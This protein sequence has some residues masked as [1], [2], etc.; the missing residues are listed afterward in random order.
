VQQIVIIGAGGFAREVLDV[1]EAANEDRSRYEVLGYVVDPKYGAPG[2]LVNDKPILGGF[3]WLRAHSKDVFAVC[4]VGSSHHRYGLVAR[5]REAGSRFISV[6]HPTVVST[7]WV[8]IAEGVVIAAGSVLTNRISIGDHVH[9]N[10][11]CTIGHDVIMEDFATLAP[12]V[13]VSGNV[14]FAQGAFMG[15]GANIIEKMRIGEWSIVGAGS[16]VVTDIP[17]NSTAVGVP[18]RVIKMSEPGWHLS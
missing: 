5:A 2:T 9:I 1:I 7:R 14:T 3:E 4:G 6:I 8:K 17:A 13:H 12:G 16:T 11:H 18:A 10:L 15:T